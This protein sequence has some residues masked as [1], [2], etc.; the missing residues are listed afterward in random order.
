MICKTRFVRVYQTESIFSK[1]SSQYICAILCYSVNLSKKGE[2]K[3]GSLLEL[4]LDV[5]YIVRA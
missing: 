4:K 1:Y 5:V 2:F 3:L